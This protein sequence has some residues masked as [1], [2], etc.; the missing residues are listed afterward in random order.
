MLIFI[1][2]GLVC[3]SQGCYWVKVD[4]LTEFTKYEACVEQASNVKRVS[5]MYFDTSCMVK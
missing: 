3:N 1:I 2:I 5:I 4:G